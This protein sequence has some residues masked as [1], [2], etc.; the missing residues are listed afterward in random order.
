MEMCVHLKV[1]ESCGC[2][3]YRPQTDGRVYCK[4]CEVKLRD[5][6]SPESRK[7]RGPRGRKALMKVWAVADAMGGVE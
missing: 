1:C 3:W 6:P 4:E 2:L 5:F 7:R